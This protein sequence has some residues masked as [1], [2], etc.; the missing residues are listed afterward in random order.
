MKKRILILV[1]HEI[2]I[3]NFRRELVDALLEQGYE[4]YIS[5]PYGKKL[6]YFIEKGCIFKE[7]SI[8]RH[9]INPFKDLRIIRTYKKLIREIKPYCIL[10]YTIKPNLY[11]AIAAK[12]TQVHVIANITG[13]GTA[14]ENGGILQKITILMYKYA[15]SN[16]QTVFFQN[17]ENMQFF[18]EKNIAVGKHKLLPGSGVNLTQF[19][20]LEYPNDNTIEFVFISRIM[21]QKGIDQYLEAAKYIREKYPFTRFHICGF[22]EEEYENILKDYQNKGFIEYHGLMNDIRDILKVTHCTVH[23]TYYPEGMSNVLL[24]SCAS[25]RP[26]ITT[27]RSGCREIVD[28]SINGYIV[29]Q[30]NTKSLICA[31]EKFL[32]LSNEQRK[33]MGISGRK[34]VEKEFDRKIVINAYIQSIEMGEEKNEL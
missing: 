20:P 22:C 17:E 29:K 19:Q 7:I 28:D 30:Q 8:D 12:R 33:Q 34:K 15:F 5:S 14:V 26:I 23:P 21:K 6:D 13:L 11:G 3:Y 16:I 25:A 1:N 2:V 18:K 24:E 10:T 4:V 27:N 9:G 31:L 32:N